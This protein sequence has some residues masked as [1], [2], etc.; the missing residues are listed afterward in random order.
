M[1]LTA[2]PR[3]D[4]SLQVA[5]IPPESAG[6]ESIESLAQRAV[7]LAWSRDARLAVAESCT[8]GAVAAA[9]AHGRRGQRVLPGWRRRVL[10]GGE[11]RDCSACSPAR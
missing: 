6:T 11:V 5:T 2:A 10:A 4:T 1:T 9:L 3:V 7:D 8:A